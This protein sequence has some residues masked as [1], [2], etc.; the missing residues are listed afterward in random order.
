VPGLVVI[1]DAP[2][3]D[4]YGVFGVVGAVGDL[5]RYSRQGGTLYVFAVER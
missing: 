5:G 4:P 1:Q 2:P 3:D